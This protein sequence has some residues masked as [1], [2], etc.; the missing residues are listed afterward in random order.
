V[1]S[2]IL[3]P[4]LT[5]AAFGRRQLAAEENSEVPVGTRAHRGRRLQRWLAASVAVLLAIAPFV[6]PSWTIDFAAAAV[7]IETVAAQDGDLPQAN[8]PAAGLEPAQPLTPGISSRLS[9]ETSLGL[10]PVKSPLIR[11]AA[12]DQPLGAIQVVTAFG[13][14]QVFHRSS[15]GTSRTPTG[16]PS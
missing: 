13:G 3:H 1:A 9:P 2:T 5:G 14:E 7:S 6:R 16:P 4:L 12:S 10:L 8:Q 15:V 11:P